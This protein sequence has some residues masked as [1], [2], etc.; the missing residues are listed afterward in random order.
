MTL[1]NCRLFLVASATG[2]HELLADCLSAAIEAG[3]VASLLL[4]DTADAGGMQQ[5]A[6]QFVPIAHAGEAAVLLDG[7]LDLADQLNADG[8]EV[9]ADLETYRS[10]RSHLGNDRIVGAYCA[11]NR[12]AAMEMAEAGADYV[13]IDP[14]AMGPDGESI[15]GWWSQLFEVPCVA[16]APLGPADM[17]QVVGNGADFVRPGD[18]MWTSPEEASRVVAES[19][20]AIRAAQA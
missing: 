16:A 5:V 4:T 6:E 20:K 17:E 2:D 9:S 8:V 18:S 19:M 12:H 11:G 10:C 7:Q 15:I 14:F 3:D 13:R 1:P